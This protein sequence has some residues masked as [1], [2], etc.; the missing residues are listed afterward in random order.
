MSDWSSDVCSSDLSD[1]HPL[2]HRLP[3]AG[4]WQGNDRS[5]DGPV[6]P[7]GRRPDAFVLIGYSHLGKKRMKNPIEHRGPEGAN[8]WR[9]AR[10][11]AIAAILV[12]PFLAM[13]G[14]DEVTWPPAELA[15]AGIH[16]QIGR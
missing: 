8:F 1:A 12:L 9:R 11:S 5:A 2:Q 6:S 3:Q 16:M 14:T 13:Q 15:V 7:A 4:P 10:W